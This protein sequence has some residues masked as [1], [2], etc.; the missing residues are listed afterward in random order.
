MHAGAT[1]ALLPKKHQAAWH[2]PDDTKRS[3]G[4][5]G[6]QAYNPRRQAEW[7]ID[8]NA[9]YRQR[10]TGYMMGGA[11]KDWNQS[12]EIASL[13]RFPER[14]MER[15]NSA[16]QSVPQY[17]YNFRAEVLPKAE[18]KGAPR[19]DKFHMDM[20]RGAAASL[21]MSTNNFIGFAEKDLGAVHQKLSNT[22]RGEMPIHPR[23]TTKHNIW[24]QGEGD[25]N[26]S[27]Q[28][29]PK[30]R[31]AAFLRQET[32]SQRTSSLSKTRLLS[33]GGS[34]A[35]Y[36]SPQQIEQARTAHL[37]ELKAQ[38]KAE[39]KDFDMKWTRDGMRHT[40]HRFNVSQPLPEVRPSRIPSSCTRSTRAGIEWCC[41]HRAVCMARPR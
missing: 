17:Y 16:F 12:V 27:T 18:I 39:G 13:N 5:D 2:R 15:Q 9:E 37:R 22:M 32:A 30:E 8:N 4:L 3:T 11:K 26:V 28:V 6:S 31:Q 1:C 35:T 24:N 38:R 29:L 10:G 21:R 25:W 36:Q 23:L 7:K 20:T 41:C 40:Y 33:S 14:R 19:H 34:G